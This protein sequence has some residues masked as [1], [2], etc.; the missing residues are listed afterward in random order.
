VA[1]RTISLKR[2]HAPILANDMP[3]ANA[4]IQLLSHVG[5]ANIDDNLIQRCAD[6]L[7]P[8]DMGAL[9]RIQAA[10]PWWMSDA[11]VKISA[12]RRDAHHHWIRRRSFSG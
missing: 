1:G 10:M 12:A 4:L 3:R 6:S 9:K 5:K 7:S 8:R 2:S 11:V